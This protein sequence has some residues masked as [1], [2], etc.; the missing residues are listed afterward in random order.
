ME[1]EP[2]KEKT[3]KIGYI[4]ARKDEEKNLNFTTTA[5]TNIYQIQ[6]T[7]SSVKTPNPKLTE[8]IGGVA[9]KFSIAYVPTF[10]LSFKFVCKV[11]VSSHNLTK[12]NMFPNKLSGV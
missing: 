7:K 2:C 6:A 8:V 10:S 1:W 12:S 3:L 5:T 9:F 11:K 4:C